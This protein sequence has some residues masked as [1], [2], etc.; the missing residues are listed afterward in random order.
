[1]PKEGQIK[2]EWR[3]INTGHNEYRFAFRKRN[4][5]ED[6]CHIYSGHVST[7][8]FNRYGGGHPI[9]PTNIDLLDVI[10]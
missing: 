6:N 7:Y 1:V 8:S 10:E 3:E 9:T 4:N 2:L 5:P